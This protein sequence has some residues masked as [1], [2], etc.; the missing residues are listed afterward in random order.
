MK[1]TRKIIFLIIAIFAL[2]IFIINN[3]KRSEIKSM[4]ISEIKESYNNEQIISDKIIHK[5]YLNGLEQI[6]K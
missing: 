5:H 3:L 4:P 2:L 6:I 1:K